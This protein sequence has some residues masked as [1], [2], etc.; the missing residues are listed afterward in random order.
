MFVVCSR[1]GKLSGWSAIFDF[2]SW[3]CGRIVLASGGIVLHTVSSG[4]Q[5]LGC[6]LDELQ[7]R[8]LRLWILLAARLGSLHAVHEW[9]VH[10]VCAGS[11]L[12]VVS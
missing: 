5:Q 10:T 6:E 11:E 4:N 9:N 3:L 7:L 1:N 2:V 12:P 8:G